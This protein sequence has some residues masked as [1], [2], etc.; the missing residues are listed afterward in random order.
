M[1]VT[2]QIS[3][4]FHCQ[5]TFVKQEAKT[6]LHIRFTYITRN[7]YA[8]PQKKTEDLLDYDKSTISSIYS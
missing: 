2:D 4:P 6:I 5:H 1:T 7:I 3:N 8:I